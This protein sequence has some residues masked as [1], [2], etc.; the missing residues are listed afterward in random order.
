MLSKEYQVP[1]FSLSYDS[2]GD[3]TLISR[4]IGELYTQQAN[5]NKVG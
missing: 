1:F 5:E 4:A 3:W 2:T